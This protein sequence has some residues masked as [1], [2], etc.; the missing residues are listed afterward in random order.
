MDIS[1]RN[2]AIYTLVHG[3][4]DVGKIA[5]RFD[6]SKTMVRKIYQQ[7]ASKKVNGDPDIPEIDKMCRI[8]QWREQ[9]RGKL[10]SILHKHGYTNFD[11]KWLVTKIDEFRKIPRIGPNG[12][13][14]IWLAQQMRDD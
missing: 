4:I 6:I 9:D 1:E 2:Q 11:N 3:G 7:Q 13:A 14:I 10:Q 8:F 5:K 12:I